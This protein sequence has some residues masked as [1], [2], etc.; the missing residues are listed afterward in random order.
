MNNEEYLLDEDDNILDDDNF[1]GVTFKPV[2]LQC[3]F[4]RI[5]EIMLSQNLEIRPYYTGY[6]AMRYRPR[7]KWVVY[8]MFTN[9]IVGSE[10]G[11]ELDDFRYLFAEMDFPLHEEKDPHKKH[12]NKGAVE[13]LKIL[14]NL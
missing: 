7:Q 6:K 3:S 1:K 9:T 13:F 10:Y 11:Y 5:K 4:W 8:D 14:E 2:Y 12:R